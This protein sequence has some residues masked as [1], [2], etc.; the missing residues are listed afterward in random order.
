MP[1][2]LLQELVRASVAE[3]GPQGAVRGGSLAG[4]P[5]RLSMTAGPSKELSTQQLAPEKSE[6]AAY[7]VKDEI[8]HTAWCWQFAYVYVNLF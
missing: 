3:G 8:L 6:S 7:L 4:L 1:A 2:A 5:R